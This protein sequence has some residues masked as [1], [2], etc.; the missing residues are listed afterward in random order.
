[1]LRL[2]QKLQALLYQDPVLPGQIHHVSHCGKCGEHQKISKGQLRR[3]GTSGPQ[4]LHQL[5]CHCRTAQLFVRIETVRLSGIDNDIR[6]RHCLLQLVMVRHDHRHAHLLC[7]SNLCRRSDAVVAGDD[8]IHSRLLRPPDQL[9]I[10]AVSVPLSV[11]NVRIHSGPDFFKA[12]QKDI[13][14]T[15]SVDVIIAD[16]P[17]IRSLPDLLH[18]KLHRLRDPLHQG[19][20]MKI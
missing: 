18:Q 5:P 7:K 1:M 8:G 10:Q 6:I 2:S 14:G 9:H 3:T 13:S 11:R 15:D 16:D 12:F 4:L 17:D 19:S 20:R